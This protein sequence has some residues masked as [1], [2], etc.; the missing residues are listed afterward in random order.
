[1]KVKSLIFRMLTKN[2]EIR[3]KDQNKCFVVLLENIGEIYAEGL[4]G[5]GK[6]YVE[7][8]IK[9]RDVI[10][11]MAK[12]FADMTGNDR[13]DTKYSHTKLK[14]FLEATDILHGEIP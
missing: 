14:R 6:N 8:V 7:A 1:M 11:L 5:L 9:Y 13:K 3:F 12:F 2:H 10:V 4:M